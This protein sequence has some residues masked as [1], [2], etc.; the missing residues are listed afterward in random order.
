MTD[1]FVAGALRNAKVVD[2]EIWKRVMR[3]SGYREIYEAC[4]EWMKKSD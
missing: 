2:E 1:F 4:E 3:W